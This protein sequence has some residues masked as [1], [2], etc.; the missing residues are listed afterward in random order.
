MPPLGA[1]GKNGRQGDPTG[2]ILG[3]DHLPSVEDYQGLNQAGQLSGPEQ[4]GVAGGTP[5]EVLLDFKEGLIQK[6]AAGADP[7]EDLGHAAPVEVIEDQDRVVGSEVGPVR[8]EVELPPIHFEPAVPGLGAGD[9]EAGRIP[10][11]RSDTGTQGGGR[12]GMAASPAGK[13][14]HPT[15][16]KDPMGMP[17]EPA[18]GPGNLGG[19]GRVGVNS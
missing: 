10:V 9:V 12:E 19:I 17:D 11:H 3:L 16:G 15:P 4:V 1:L 14:E 18:A 8:L 13:I 6:D 2:V 5:P 7:G